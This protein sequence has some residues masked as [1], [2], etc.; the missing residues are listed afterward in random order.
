MFVR[1]VNKGAAAAGTPIQD[2]GSESDWFVVAVLGTA[3]A[4]TDDA[5]HHAALRLWCKF[6]I[7][8]AQGQMGPFQSEYSLEMHNEKNCVL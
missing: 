2:S 3:H 1:T 4:E 8:W 7:S 6:H 5:V